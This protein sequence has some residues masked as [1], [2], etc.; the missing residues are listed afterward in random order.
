MF[1]EFRDFVLR[2]NVVEL[3]VAVIIGAAFGKIVDAAVKGLVTPLIGIFGGTPDFSANTFSINGSVFLWGDVV[4]AIVAFLIVALVL[5]FLIVKPMNT[6]MVR[7]KRQ[8]EISPPA[9]TVD[10][11]LLTEIRDLLKEQ[12]AR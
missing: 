11:K 1:K 5:F 2:G 6:L 4:N 8:E 12:S 3:A 10:Q 7:M 9:P